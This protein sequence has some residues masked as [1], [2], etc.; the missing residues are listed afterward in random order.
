MLAA[1]SRNSGFRQ[2]LGRSCL[3]RVVPNK[4]FSL[5]CVPLGNTFQLTNNAAL[6]VQQE[7]GWQATHF[8]RP[9]HGHLAVHIKRKIG[10][11]EFLEKWF[12][13]RD[14]T[15]IFVYGD[16]GEVFPAKLSLQLVDTGHLTDTRRTPRRPEVDQHDLALEV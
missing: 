3:L 7:A 8:K 9:H 16:D 15:S 1:L 14:A 5:G 12:R 11:T 13:A 10:C 2:S 6:A 4:I